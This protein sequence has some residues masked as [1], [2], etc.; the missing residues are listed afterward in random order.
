MNDFL[1]PP[2]SDQP[3]RR[4][5]RALAWLFVAFGLFTMGLAIQVIL[6]NGMLGD[7]PLKAWGLCGVALYMTALFLSSAIHGKAPHGWIPWESGGQA[8]PDDQAP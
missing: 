6:V 1:R 5:V 7:L 3:L 8:L 4:S 2:W